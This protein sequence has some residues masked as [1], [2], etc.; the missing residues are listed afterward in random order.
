MNAASIAAMR[1]GSVITAT[2]VPPCPEMSPTIPAIVGA[3]I[4]VHKCRY[5]GSGEWTV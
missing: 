5:V 1:M 2:I 4:K 3:T